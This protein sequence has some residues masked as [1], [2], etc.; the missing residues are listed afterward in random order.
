MNCSGPCHQGRERCKTPE[1]CQV[2]IESDDAYD[3]LRDV[4][5]AGRD[6]VIAISAAFALGLVVSLIL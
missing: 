4:L 1:A 5:D 2:P 6:V 3:L